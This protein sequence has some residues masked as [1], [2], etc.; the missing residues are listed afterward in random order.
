MLVTIFAPMVP[1]IH[2]DAEECACK[3]RNAEQRAGPVLY[4]A[5]SQNL[6]STGCVQ[7]RSVGV[8]E[9]RRP[10][11]KGCNSHRHGNNFG[12]LEDTLAADSRCVASCSALL[13]ASPKSSTAGQKLE[14]SRQRVRCS[15]VRP[16]CGTVWFLP[17]RCVQCSGAFVSVSD[18]APTTSTVAWLLEKLRAS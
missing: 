3:A 7:A 9:E 11:R 14:S 18:C 15:L 1:T 16:P 5:R 10:L 8:I 2:T 6:I 12:H 4:E 17:P 13:D